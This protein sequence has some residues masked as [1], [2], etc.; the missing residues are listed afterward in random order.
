MT[1]ELQLLEKQVEVLLSVSLIA[2]VE[3]ALQLLS[4]QNCEKLEFVP[5]DV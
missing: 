5:C 2:S 3:L 4:T 1:L